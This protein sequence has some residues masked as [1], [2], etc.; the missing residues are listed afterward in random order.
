MSD[1]CDAVKRAA[2]QAPPL[3]QVAVALLRQLGLRKGER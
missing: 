1:Y 2:N 3:P